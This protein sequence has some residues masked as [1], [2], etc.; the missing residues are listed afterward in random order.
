[1]ATLPFFVAHIQWVIKSPGPYGTREVGYP[2][3]PKTIG[4]HLRKRRLDLKLLQKDVART[5]GC[6]AL[7]LVNWEKGHTKPSV[8]HMAG[9]VGF[10]GFNPLP[11]R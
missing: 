7:T 10:L 4:E 9:V 6:T 5:I 1:M 2:H 3:S 8:N 11:Q